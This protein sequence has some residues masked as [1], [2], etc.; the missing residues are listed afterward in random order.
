VTLVPLW[1]QQRE[2]II[3]MIYRTHE[4]F[5]FL[6]FDKTVT[7]GTAATM[8]EAKSATGWES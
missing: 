4:G 6:V 2:G 1:T 7:S 5:H 3:R 8:T